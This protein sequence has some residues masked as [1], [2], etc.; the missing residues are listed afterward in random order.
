MMDP[1]EEFLA[2]DSLYTSAQ[3]ER[4]EKGIEDEEDEPV[5]RDILLYQSLTHLT[6]LICNLQSKKHQSPLN[7]PLTKCSP[8]SLQKCKTSNPPNP[9]PYPNPKQSNLQVPLTSLYSPIDSKTSS[10]ISMYQTF[11]TQIMH[12][13]TSIFKK[14]V[15][16][17]LGS[18][19][20]VA[21]E[22]NL[23]INK[24]KCLS[25]MHT[26]RFACLCAKCG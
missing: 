10:K 15:L 13:Q 12:L 17:P 22:H 3:K 20:Q 6:S 8:L 4:I 5:Q 21:A 9:K 14:L 11:I 18:L 7:P 19:G 26:F 1:L 23:F 24:S 25:F 2:K 16:V